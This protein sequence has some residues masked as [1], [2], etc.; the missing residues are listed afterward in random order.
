MKALINCFRN[1]AL[2]CLGG[3]LLCLVVVLETG[4][5]VRRMAVNKLGD[6]LAQS[7]SSYARDNDPELIR[8]AV[9]FSL[10]LMESL[11]DEAPR[12]TG[13]LLAAARGFTQYSY[14]FVQQEADM[15]ETEN[16]N[17]SLALR[18]RAQK[19]YQRAKEYG[20]RGLEIRHPGF[21]SVLLT[22][23][24]LALASTRRDDV[25]LLYW[26]GAAWGSSISLN[27][28]NP[29]MI[30]D[31]PIVEAMLDRAMRLNAA[32][33]H[34]ALHSLMITLEGAR[35][36]KPGDP[37]ARMR[38]HFQRAMAL[39]DGQLAGPLVALAESASV[40]QQNLKEFKSLLEQALAID[41]DVRPE[42]R[43]EN[44]IMQKR[45][46]WLLDRVDELFL[47]NHPA[48]NDEQEP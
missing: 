18:D 38:E 29:E 46:R 42:W 48:E 10:K 14:A 34:G 36:G 31:F 45:A 47:I 22:N 12:H 4:C 9:P 7:G 8:Q 41:P 6:A 17:Q 35:R 11:L 3:A 28:D 30:A 19:L 27:K 1:Q 26:T 20:L 37:Y 16:F 32:F 23:A 21:R 2:R 44:L 13:L 40:Q 24:P 43:L 39:S 15:V 33:N 5:S 25:P